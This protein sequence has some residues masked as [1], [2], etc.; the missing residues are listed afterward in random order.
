L[1]I[2]GD[3]NCVDNV[4]DK[5][6]FSFVPV[7]DQKLLCSLRADFSLTDIW[8]KH[9]LH[10]VVFTWF[11]DHTQASRIDRFLVA[12]SL[13]SKASCDILP[14]VL[15]DH[16]FLKIE[17]IAGFSKRGSGVWRFNN[18]LL[19]DVEFRNVLSKAIANYKLK[20]PDFTSLRKWWDSLKTEIRRISILYSTRKRR[21]WRAIRDSPLGLKWANK[22][23]VLGVFF[24]YGLVGVDD[25]NWRCKLDKLSSVFN[26]WKQ[27]DL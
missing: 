14:F 24:S 6:N 27:R 10:S 7:S 16:D 9:N 17:F 2:G 25:D 21:G 26:L 3:F 8:R 18:S 1:V 20:I 12:N 13:V 15:S 5:L 23:R 22:M 11:N 19:S 4:L